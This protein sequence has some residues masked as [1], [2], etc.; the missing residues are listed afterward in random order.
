MT[1]FLI[2]LSDFLFVPD[3]A[4]PGSDIFVYP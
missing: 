3:I 1:I 2:D 4:D